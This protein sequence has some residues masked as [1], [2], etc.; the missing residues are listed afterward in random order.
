MLGAMMQ[1]EWMDLRFGSG[2]QV[3]YLKPQTLNLNP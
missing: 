1:A 2:S 3:S